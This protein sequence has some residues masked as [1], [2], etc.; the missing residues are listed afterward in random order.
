MLTAAKQE[1]DN[2]DDTDVDESKT[3]EEP[4]KP[5]EP[6]QEE[7]VAKL[8]HVILDDSSADNTANSA[9]NTEAN[10]PNPIATTPAPTTHQLQKIGKLTTANTRKA[11]AVG[12]SVVNK[13]FGAMGPC[14]GK[15]SFVVVVVVVVFCC[16]CR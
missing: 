13:Y 10:K 15:S 1:D 9:D 5:E 3:K 14:V 11:G 7:L 4:E 16:C 12:C 6:D 8:K 2:D